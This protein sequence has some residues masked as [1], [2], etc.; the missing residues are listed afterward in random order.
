MPLQVGKAA[1]QNLVKRSRYIKHLHVYIIIYIMCVG[2]E[3]SVKTLWMQYHCSLNSLQIHQDSKSLDAAQ[4]LPDQSINHQYDS[5]MVSE[6][7]QPL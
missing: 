6:L 3:E 4:I 2:A 1:I 5:V 7:C